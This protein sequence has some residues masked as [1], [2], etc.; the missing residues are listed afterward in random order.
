MK[1]VLL[2]LSI[3]I[4][5]CAVQ[6]VPVKSIPAPSPVPIKPVCPKGIKQDWCRPLAVGEMGTTVLG[7]HYE[8]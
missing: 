6:P 5:G 4:A 2:L 7:N 1:L 3:F 8:D